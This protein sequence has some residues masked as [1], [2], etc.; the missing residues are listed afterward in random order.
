MKLSLSYKPEFESLKELLIKIAAQKSIDSIL[1]MVVDNFIQRPNIAI[2]RIWLKKKGDI[3]KNCFMSG[4]CRNPKECLHLA[5]SKG[6]SIC[7]KE[8]NWSVLEDQFMRIPMGY[9]TIGKVAWKKRDLSKKEIEKEFD[10]QEKD[11][12]AKG[13]KIAG[14]EIK[15]LLFDN[16]MLGVIAIYSRTK[17]DRDKEGKFRVEMIAHSIAAAIANSETY[18][19]INRLNSQL[20]LENTFLKKEINETRNYGSIIGKSPNL[21][22]I[23]EQIELVAKT[24]VNIFIF[25]EPGT[26]KEL[27]AREIHNKSPRKT[28]PLIKVNCGTIP[29]KLYKSKFFG[30][31]KGGMSGNIHKGAG[32]FE[33]ADKGTLFLDEAGD[34]PVKFQS[35]FLRVL[36][37]GSYE[38]LGENIARNINA[39]IIAATSRNI[40]ND[41]KQ[42]R[43]RQDL[44]YKLNVFPIHIDPLRERKEDIKLL[45]NYFLKRISKEMQKTVPDISKQGMKKLLSYSWPGNVR[46]LQNI[47]ERAVITFQGKKLEFSISDNNQNC[48]LKAKAMYKGEHSLKVLTEEQISLLSMRNTINALKMCN[49]KI[50]GQ[51]GAAALLKIPPTTLSSRLKKIQIPSDLF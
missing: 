14:F 21:M 5:A 38:R 6:E 12:W 22:N 24:D 17:A 8:K 20:E 23:L 7:K 18:N 43:F 45:A 42:G 30:S 44:F 33:A 11:I 32:M 9:S 4:N 46:E 36:Q 41:I 10:W 25:G 28:M 1:N 15:P 49:G 39:R 31:I 26:G 50:Y 51:D 48:A 34:L 13:E 3:C 16:R 40:K 47:I 19:E 35:K 29:E 27:I 2:V 37:K